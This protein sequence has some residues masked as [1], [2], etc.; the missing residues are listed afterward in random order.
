MNKILVVN[1]GDENY[2]FGKMSIEQD[3]II[4]NSILASI[5]NIN[6]NF[7]VEYYSEEINFLA[8]DNDDQLNDIL[9]DIRC[10]SIGSFYTLE[11][12]YKELCLYLDLNDTVTGFF[13]KK[14]MNNSLLETI[15]SYIE[16]NTTEILVIDESVCNDCIDKTFII[17][18][19][20]IATIIK[21]ADRMYIDCYQD[22]IDFNFIQD[23]DHL[24][25]ILESNKLYELECSCIDTLD[26]AFKNLLEWY[27]IDNYNITDI[28]LEDGVNVWRRIPYSPNSTKYIKEKILTEINKQK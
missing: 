21:N 24:N 7:S 11:E 12:A 10:Y 16:E 19:K 20:Y 15:V 5:S 23:E 18:N 25:E 28:K 6:G 17:D 22:Q 8:L 1:S 26:D 2:V 27:H 3:L 9:N 14:I 13:N 4:N